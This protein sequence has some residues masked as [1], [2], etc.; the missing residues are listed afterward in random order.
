MIELKCPQCN[1]RLRVRE[2]AP[3]TRGRCPKCGFALV[4]PETVSASQ[5]P[6]A[7]V[8]E[9]SAHSTWSR[10]IE[11]ELE[12]G[13]SPSR[14]LP[15]SVPK[16]AHSSTASAPTDPFAFLSRDGDSASDSGSADRQT[17]HPT[18]N[19]SWWDRQFS[20]MGIIGLVLLPF[21]CGLPALILGLIGMVKCTDKKAASNAKWMVIHSAVIIFVGLAVELVVVH[22]VLTG[23]KR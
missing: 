13:V 16:S 21:C 17:H 9:N 18:I 3:G 1:S 2:A 4:V 23:A 8:D 19:R 6:S 20:E 15:T 12:S 14:P 7:P 5:D 11:D 22:G 10:P